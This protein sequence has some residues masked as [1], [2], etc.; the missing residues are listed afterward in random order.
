M[1]K[2]HIILLNSSITAGS[3]V[4]TKKSESRTDKVIV[5]IRAV[6]LTLM[7]FNNI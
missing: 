5:C 1:L 3:R 7:K 2:Y 4:E 6:E